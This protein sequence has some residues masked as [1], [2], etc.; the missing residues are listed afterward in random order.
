MTDTPEET[1]TPEE[2]DE[3]VGAYYPEDAEDDNDAPEELR[4]HLADD[5]MKLDGLNKAIIGVDTNGYLVYD[6]GKIVEVFVADHDMSYEEAM[7]F[8]DFN[9]VG[10]GGGNWTIMNSRENYL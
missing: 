10:I 1:Q 3:A 8:T 7:E 9:V 6:Y 5:S 2:Q 4:D